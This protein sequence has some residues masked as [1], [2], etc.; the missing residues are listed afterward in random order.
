MVETIFAEI[1]RSG[2]NVSGF[3]IAG[4]LVFLGLQVRGLQKS[5]DKLEALVLPKLDNHG[6]RL[7]NIEGGLGITHNG[8]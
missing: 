7:S 3:F 6:S 4:G 2:G 8:G 1:I 5:F